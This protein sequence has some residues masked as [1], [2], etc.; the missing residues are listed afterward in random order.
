MCAHATCTPVESAALLVCQQA[1]ITVWIT[2]AA[3]RVAVCFQTAEYRDAVVHNSSSKDVAL[4]IGCHAGGCDTGVALSMQT[5]VR[6]AG[7]ACCVLDAGEPALWW[8]VS[9]HA[10]TMGPTAAELVASSLRAPAGVTTRIIYNRVKRVLGVDTT[11]QVIDEAR[12]KWVG[13][14]GGP[15]LGE[16]VGGVGGG[17]VLAAVC[18]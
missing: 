2:Q 5:R 7:S 14:S 3:K 13:T 15:R 9:S 16:G 12:Q 11:K 1:Q 10:F 18:A 17:G 4:E 8:V 6:A